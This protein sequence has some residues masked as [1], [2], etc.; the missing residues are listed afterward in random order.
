MIIHTCALAI[1]FLVDHIYCYFLVKTEGSTPNF[2]KE[3]FAMFNPN[4]N[5]MVD[6]N[7]LLLSA[8]ADYELD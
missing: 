5:G 7:K 6:T 2:D 8:W 3:S 1:D 4:L